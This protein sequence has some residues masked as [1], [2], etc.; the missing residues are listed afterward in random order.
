MSA[1]QTAWRLACAAWM[2]AAFAPKD[3]RGERLQ[4]AHRAQL[5]AEKLDPEGAAALL[6]AAIA[7]A[8][9]CQ[10]QRKNAKADP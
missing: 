8:K 9:R 10:R 6:A 5:R 3:A 1:A 2:S 7:S 4:A